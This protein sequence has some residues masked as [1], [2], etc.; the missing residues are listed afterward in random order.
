LKI[1][2]P[3]SLRAPRRVVGNKRDRLRPILV[4]VM[5]L[6]LGIW[7]Y[8]HFVVGPRMTPAPIEP[9]P[10]DVF[11]PSA[12]AT[13]APSAAAEAPNAP[14]MD[15]GFV[16]DRRICVPRP[17]QA[18]DTQ[19]SA[20]ERVNRAL[21]I[22]QDTQS[23]AARASGRPNSPM[24]PDADMLLRDAENFCAA[25]RAEG[26]IR[27]RQCRAEQWHWFRERC[28]HWRGQLQ[29]ASAAQADDVR[30]RATAYCEAERRYQIVK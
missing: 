11:P 10:A 3:E 19:P 5:A 8:L 12:P 22:M 14:G 30:A 28:I 17:S 4:G 18:V 26:T 25:F 20:A 29:T 15:C 2:M 7:A 6:G 23:Q 16:N 1:T 13:T 24:Y 9:P 21:D 27:Y